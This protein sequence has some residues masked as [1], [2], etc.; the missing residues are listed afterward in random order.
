MLFK[1]ISRSQP[2]VAYVVVKNVSGGTI[3]AGYSV[4]WDISATTDGVNVTQPATASLG[5]FAGVA[6]SNIASNAYGLIQVYGY[7][8]STYVY[9]STGSSA[10]GE[11]LNT[12]NAEWGLTPSAASSASAK[13]FAF[14]C[15]AVTGSSSSR[16]HLNAK[17]FIRAL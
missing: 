7:R 1:R 3:T 16:Y 14:L 6:D 8:A 11:G 2:E 9:S 12:V 15:E 17:A 4:V 13:S 5:C 10:A